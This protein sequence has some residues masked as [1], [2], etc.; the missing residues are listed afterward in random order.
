MLVGNW[1]SN[2]EVFDVATREHIRTLEGHAA[3]VWGI[4]FHPT[5]PDIFA[6]CSSDGT[7]RLWSLASGRDLAILNFCP[8]EE[9]IAASFS[10]DGRRIA[11]AGSDSEVRVWNMQYPDR[12]IEGNFDCQERRAILTRAGSPS[13]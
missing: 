2:I 8:G 12:C 3:T 6:S 11:V 1:H 10:P 7:V 5:E 4:Q 9:A 13:D